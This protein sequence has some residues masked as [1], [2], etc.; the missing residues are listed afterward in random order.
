MKKLVMIILLITI[1]GCATVE[2]NPDTGNVKY[3][4][5]GDQHIQ[6]FEVKRTADGGFRVK[7]EGQE[8]EASALT[9]AIKVIG[10]LTKVAAP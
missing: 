10:V 2:F 6:G 3:T 1:T 9:E 5:M 4:R 7:M 8:S